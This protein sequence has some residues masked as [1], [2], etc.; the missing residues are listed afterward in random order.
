M[1]IVAPYANLYDGLTAAENLQFIRRL[2]GLTSDDRRVHDLLVQVGLGGRTDDLVS[3]YSSGMVQRLRMAAALLPEPEILLLDEASITLDSAGSDLLSDT[4][5]RTVEAGGIVVAATNLQHEA[6]R[7]E[8]V[9][10][11]REFA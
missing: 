7:Y 4:I 11:V 6:E 9:V 2:R 10:D 1:G 5:D 3:T 8:C